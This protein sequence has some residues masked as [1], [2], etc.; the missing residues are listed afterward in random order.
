MEIDAE[1]PLKAEADEQSEAVSSA[2]AEEDIISDDE[3]RLVI[4]EGV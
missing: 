1:T 3:N 4:A 2:E